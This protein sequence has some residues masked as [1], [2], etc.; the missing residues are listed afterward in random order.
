MASVLVFR[1]T[2]DFL[3]RHALRRRSLWLQIQPLFSKRE[4]YIKVYIQP[5]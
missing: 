1:N 5:V 2:I 4:H 3:L